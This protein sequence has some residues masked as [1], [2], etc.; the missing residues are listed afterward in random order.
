ME[1]RAVSLITAQCSKASHSIARITSKGLVFGLSPLIHPQKVCKTCLTHT[2]SNANSEMSRNPNPG[3]LSKYAIERKKAG[4]TRSEYQPL[5][6]KSE[7]TAVKTGGTT[8]HS[9]ELTHKGP[10]RRERTFSQVSMMYRSHLKDIMFCRSNVGT[11]MKK[12]RH[13]IIL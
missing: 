1:L 11:V 13:L 7:K 10:Y 2:K 5:R 8:S 3:N 4:H 12:T 6:I 9:S